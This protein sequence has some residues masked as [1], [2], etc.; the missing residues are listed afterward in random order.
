M[1][2]PGESVLGKLL[3][4]S[5]YPRKLIHF[6]RRGS[7]VIHQP[8]ER[9]FFSSL[10]TVEGPSES[11][12]SSHHEPKVCIHA[13][14]ARCSVKATAAGGELIE[15][16]GRGQSPFGH[17]RAKCTADGVTGIKAFSTV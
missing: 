13:A 15:P 3:E 11:P 17:Q 2:K 6:P 12:L 1:R 5:C 14:S 10:M 8:E 16:N 7:V 4:F 9:L